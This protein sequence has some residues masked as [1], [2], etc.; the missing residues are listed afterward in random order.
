MAK[1]TLDVIQSI[2]TANQYHPPVKSETSTLAKPLVT[3]SRM[4]GANGSVIAELL[5]KTMGVQLYDRELL[6][7][8]IKEAKGDAHIM[9]QLDERANS[10]MDEIIR[11]FFINQAGANSDFFRYMAKVIL[12]I[13]S[14][15]GVIVGRGAHLIIP[16]DRPALR[17][18]IEGSLE[19]C[20]QR[21]AKR[22]DIKESKAE[23]MIIEKNRER[24]KFVEKIARK[25]PSPRAYYDLT[26]NTD[27]LEPERVVRIILV[28]LREVGFPVPTLI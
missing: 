28:A 25:Y 24:D 14:S 7:A 27:F 17:V 6:K 21:I 23:K 22:L 1:F 13:C 16:V 26:I 5:A 9:E 3:M 12:G 11:G 2:L 8:V 10:A 19:K 18:R 15:G 20:T 4:F